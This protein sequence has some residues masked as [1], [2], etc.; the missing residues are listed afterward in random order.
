MNIEE[1][2]A[3]LAAATDA[4]LKEAL[5]AIS[6]KALAVDDAPTKE[7]VEAIEAL[8][9]S[10][11]QV[12]A[13]LATREG[14]AAKLASAK[15]AFTTAGDD[16]DADKADADK[17]KAGADKAAAE[18][19]PAEV[20]EGEPA[21]GDA[22]TAS[23][24]LGSITKAAKATKKVSAFVGQVAA[25]TRM[26]A[27]SARF[28]SGTQLTRET[29]ADALLEKHQGIRNTSATGRHEVARIEFS[30]PDERILSKD[31]SAG[32][33]TKKIEAVRELAIQPD[34]LVAA[35]GLC[36][37]LETLYD[38]NVLGL[39][40]R[41]VRDALSRFQVDRGGIQYRMP[42]DALAMTAGLG[43][44]TATD[45]A[46]VSNPPDGTPQKTCAVIE[47]PG[48]EDATVQ[49]IYLCLQYPNFSARFD[50]EWV[51]ATTRAAQISFARFAENALL[52]QLFAGSKLLYD[53][54]HVS[55]I[56]DVLVAID[57]TVAYYRNRHR[58]D[59]MV[60][61]R[62]IMPRWVLDLFRADLTRGL[63]SANIPEH[64]GVADSTIMGWFRARGV[65]ITFHLDGLPA[66]DNGSAG[67]TP[68]DTPAQFY[69]NAAANAQI[70]GFID[71]IDALLFAEGDWLFLDGG[72]LD[73]GLVRDSG[74]NAINR[75]QTFMETWEGTA[76]DGIESL[77]LVLEVQPTGSVTGT[78]DGSAFVD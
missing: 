54:K 47:C 38:I 66:A 40:S 63:G 62:M 73:L 64:M 43:I 67:A 34:A 39:T 10:Y 55:A 76:F 65:N 22:V 12:Q 41:P 15:A 2:L 44:W 69:A 1:L 6:A 56:R 45:D 37:P 8:Q 7:N 36:A 48:L 72:T 42:M 25:T 21:E 49:A 23:A 16:T 46:A 3:S 32:V 71:R 78:I 13:E 57:K 74:L 52:T 28:A 53:T 58:L 29:L 61:L 77:R 70:P 24:K 26:V 5:G 14:N 51:D 31:A 27:G 20:V 9:A 33:N 18:D 19:K 59:S 75:Y 30:Y 4:E 60:P 35:G 11:A 17:D 50:R 68:Q